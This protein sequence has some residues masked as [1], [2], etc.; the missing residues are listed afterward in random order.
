V[1]ASPRDP[2]MA[3]VVKIYQTIC[4]H[5]GLCSQSPRNHI[6]L[7]GIMILDKIWHHVKQKQQKSWIWKALDRDSRQL[8]TLK[9][10]HRDQA[11]STQM[12]QRPP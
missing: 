11:T 9:R 10:R 7:K 12:V 6:S 4:A 2:L 1:F 3:S 8:L 5:K